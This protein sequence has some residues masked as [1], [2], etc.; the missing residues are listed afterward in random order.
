M[1]ATTY[2]VPV[3][4]SMTGVLVI[5]NSGVMVEQSFPRFPPPLRK[6]LR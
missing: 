5:P 6:E 1:L 2:N 3:E 4:E